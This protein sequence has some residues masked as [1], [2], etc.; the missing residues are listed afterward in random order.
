MNKIKKDVLKYSLKK[1]YYILPPEMKLLTINLIDL[2]NQTNLEDHMSYFDIL[3]KMDVTHLISSS[4][5]MDN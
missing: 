2:E 3:N 5:Q 1:E 4:I